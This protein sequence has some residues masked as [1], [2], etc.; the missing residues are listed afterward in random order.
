MSLPRLEI[1]VH[2]VY[3]R[4]TVVSAG[5]KE[6]DAEVIYLASYRVL[7]TSYVIK[8]SKI[9]AAAGSLSANY[10]VVNEFHG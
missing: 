5:A 9:T 10:L 7:S 8:K 1:V 6:D 2:S 3:P 4:H